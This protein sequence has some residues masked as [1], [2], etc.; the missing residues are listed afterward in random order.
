MNK[1]ASSIVIA[2]VL[3]GCSNSSP[4]AWRIASSESSSS[5]DAQYQRSLQ[6][7]S[8][9]AV[10]PAEA[11]STMLIGTYRQGRSIVR[12]ESIISE[13]GARNENM[14]SVVAGPT[15]ETNLGNLQKPS[16]QEIQRDLRQKFSGVPMRVIRQPRSNH[17]GL[18]GLAVGYSQG[19][20]RCIY[21]WQWIDEFLPGSSAQDRMAASV[22][23]HLCRHDASLEQLASYF[24]KIRIV[25]TF[26]DQ[27]PVV[28]AERVQPAVRSK[29]AASRSEQ[30]VADSSRQRIQPFVARD[31][32]VYLALPEGAAPR[33]DPATTES[34]NLAA[35]R[36]PDRPFT[37]PENSLPPEAY[38]GPKS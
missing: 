8:Y 22:R 6:T 37:R 17:Y 18:F 1:C 10:L 19:T 32:R 24:E 34:T 30:P 7:S 11:G 5:L 38:R 21:T 36:Q 33:P 9:R 13:Q 23:M 35:Q 4:N 27:P 16:E 26:D 3:G 20:G 15:H 14:I 12:K 25:E 29:S 28:V 31:G 2:L